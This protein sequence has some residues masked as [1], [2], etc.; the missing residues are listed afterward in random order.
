MS[1]HENQKEKDS[2]NPSETDQIVSN[3]KRYKEKII[4]LWEKDVKER[5]PD[6][7]CN[8]PD[9]LRDDLP[10]FLDS[11]LIGISSED[12]KT[13]PPSIDFARKHAETRID[14]REYKV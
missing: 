13:Q 7:L 6:N 12:T 9:E 5:L 1:Q 8:D 14:Q 3:L 4:Q 10:G 2:K 11:L